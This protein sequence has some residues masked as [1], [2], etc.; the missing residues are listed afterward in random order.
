[1]TSEKVSKPFERSRGGSASDQIVENPAGQ[2]GVDPLDVS[3][4]AQRFHVPANRV[5]IVS[6]EWSGVAARA[7]MVAPVVDGRTGQLRQIEG[8]QI[9]AGLL[10]QLLTDRQ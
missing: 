7:L 3:L 4:G 10:H 5:Q 9:D 1:M 2:L 6:D 8:K